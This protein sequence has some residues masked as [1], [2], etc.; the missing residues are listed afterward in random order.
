MPKGVIATVEGGF[1]TLDFVDT[2]LRGPSLDKLIKIGG[3]GTIETLTRV[4]NS[5]RRQ[6]KVPEGNA[7]EAG[8]L[9]GNEAAWSNPGDTGAAEALAASGG[10]VNPGEHGEDWHTPTAEHSSA[11]AYVAQEPN[12]NVLQAKRGAVSPVTANQNAEVGGGFGG[13]A[14]PTP[15]RELIDHVLE[16]SDQRAVGG[17]LPVRTPDP[18][19]DHVNPAASA[20]LG[21]ADQFGAHRSD[22]GSTPDVGGESRADEHP[23]ARVQQVPGDVQDAF[24]ATPPSI[25]E[26]GPGTVGTNALPEPTEDSS[27]KEIDA[28]GDSIGVDTTK[29]RSRADA[30]KLIAERKAGDGNDQ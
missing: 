2:S 6:Y 17:V 21:L 7:R 30:L 26:H 23:P 15:H 29:A 12:A 11:N 19:K 18:A 14:S 28:Y 9:D 16:N 20:N 13:S 1:A 8:L 24:N 3:P 27:R 25:P 5:P 10:N 4:K 22:P